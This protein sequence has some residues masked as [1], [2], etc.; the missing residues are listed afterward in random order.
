MKFIFIIGPSRCGTTMM[1]AILNKNK[2]VFSFKEIHYFDELMQGSNLHDVPE[3]DAATKLLSKLICS[4]EEE[5]WAKHHYPKYTEQAVK[6]LS[7]EALTY[8][9]IYQ[10]FAEYYL[11]INEK[12]IACEQTPRYVQHM[13]LLYEEYPNAVF[14]NMVRDPRD[15]ILSQKK[16]WRRRFLGGTATYRETFRSWIQY[17]PILSSKIFNVNVN[18]ALKYMNMDRFLVVKYEDFVENP[19][20]SLHQICEFSH[21]EYSDEMLEIGHTSSSYVDS[22]KEK[23]ISKQRSLAWKNGGLNATE[24]Y[25]IEKYTKNIIKEFNYEHNPVRPNYFLLA[26][27]YL[28]LPVQVCFIFAVNLKRLSVLKYFFKND[29][30]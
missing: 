20:K 6:M 12:L 15:S 9:Q 28:I 5:H 30:K 29:K 22:R 21:I 23:G 17:N 4:Q 7:G 24:M 26:F 14:I 11:Q 27:Y 19:Q 10:R 8:K 1:A 18:A 2:S 3:S 13:N 25:L 16:R